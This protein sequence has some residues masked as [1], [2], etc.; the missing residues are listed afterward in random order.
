MSRAN[1]LLM[2]AAL[3]AIVFSAV[4]P[5]AFAAGPAR[6]VGVSRQAWYGGQSN[7]FPSY[8]F[9]YY[10][11]FLIPPS[12]PVAPRP[13]MPNGWW[14][15]PYPSEDPRQD[16]Y[17]PRAGYRWEDVTTLILGTS[18]KKAQI[19]LDGNLIG[20]ATDLG[21]IQLPLGDHTL[22][23]EASGYEPSETVL[24][25][26]TPSVQRMQINL[27]ATAAAKPSR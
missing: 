13:Y 26:S 9:G 7:F 19:T 8:G 11:P 17:N 3:W 2:K 27:R 6:S 23:V 12:T 14:A 20:S 5:M 15:G 1:T 21:P 25:V 16:G 24:K 10:S 22:R 4:L 18:P